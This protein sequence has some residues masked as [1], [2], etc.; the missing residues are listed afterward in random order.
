MIVTSFDNVQRDQK[1]LNN[2][3][4][5]KNPVGRGDYWTGKCRDKSENKNRKM[6]A[7]V[8]ETLSGINCWIKGTKKHY[9]HT[10]QVRDKL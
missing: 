4:F 1:A 5:Q 7:E 3:I 10:W 9:I 6:L 8:L 2:I